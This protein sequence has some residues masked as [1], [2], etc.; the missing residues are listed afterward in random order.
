MRRTTRAVLNLHSVAPVTTPF[1]PAMPPRTF[2]RLLDEL[3]RIYELRSLAELWR[4]SRRPVASLSFDDGYVDF[5]E[6]AAPI[7]RR[8]GIPANLNVITDAIERG[9]TPWNVQMYDWLASA[10]VR[11]LRAIRLEGWSAPSIDDHP[12]SR[13]RFGTSMSRHLKHRPWAER[14]ALLGELRERFR[15]APATRRMM[16]VDQLRGLTADFEIGNHSA[17]HE[18]MAHQPPGFFEADY[19]RSQAWLAAALGRAPSIYAFPN[20]S[21]TAAQV[22]FLKGRGTEHVLLVD[23]RFA[24]RGDA[25]TPRVSMHGTLGRMM[26]AAVGGHA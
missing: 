1:W 23:E 16:T 3:A 13:G 12:A 14:E 11:E 18:S 17:S 2:E 4:P 10:S 9:E 19:E 15:S 6:H 25:A 26:V 8:K 24:R 22:A 20:G 21:Y 7:L 5:A